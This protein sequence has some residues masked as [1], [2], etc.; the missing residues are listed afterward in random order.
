M[1]RVGEGTDQ[2]QKKESKEK[3]DACREE[4]AG[5]AQGQEFGALPMRL[6]QLANYIATCS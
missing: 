5:R 3:E 1:G 6:H 2:S 4:R